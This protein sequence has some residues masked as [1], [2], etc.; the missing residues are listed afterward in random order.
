MDT[1]K[2]R[3]KHPLA[4]FKPVITKLKETT[5]HFLC[6]TLSGV[7]FTFA[8]ALRR[9]ILSDIP[10]VA[11]TTEPFEKCDAIIYT[12]TTM[13]SNEQLLHRLRQIPVFYKKYHD[14]A[15]HD[16]LLEVNV[17][18]TTENIQMVTTNDFKIKVKSTN[19]YLPDA[20][21]K[22]MFPCFVSGK[23][24][25]EFHLPLA[26]LRPKSTSFFCS[27]KNAPLLPSETIGT[28]TG[29]NNSNDGDHL[30]LE[31]TF[32][33]RKAKE[34]GVYVV[35]STCA[36]NMTVDE[37]KV[38]RKLQSEMIPKWK[39]EGKTT[40]EE[41][42][43]ETENWRKLDGCREVLSNSFDFRIE[44]VGTYSNR[45]L[46]TMAC[47]VL[48]DRFANVVT[49]LPSMQMEK[50]DFHGTLEN[51]FCVSLEEGAD[52]TLGYVLDKLLYYLFFEGASGQALYSFCG[53]NIAHK[54]KTSGVFR[55]AFRPFDAFVPSQEDLQKLLVL[56]FQE[57]ALLAKQVFFDIKTHM[58]HLH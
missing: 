39:S 40:E 17:Q 38:E 44:T 35:A 27:S 52:Y 12:N 54:E 56:H 8:N 23:D 25:S 57:A 20:T 58:L 51:C 31:C 21:V 3:S 22:K 41:L 28:G 15:I 16:F 42:A 10:V 14:P 48:M 49:L 36:Y 32:S 1:R 30:H 53:F 5:D 45:E 9:T 7:D 24:G 19:S 43:F 11:F 13:Q 18:N 4:H 26:R 46:V 2:E 33:V 47:D 50:E 37:S 6:F 34:N 55:I 29:T